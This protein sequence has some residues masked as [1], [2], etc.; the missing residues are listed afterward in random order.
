M[1][2]KAALVGDMRPLS[3]LLKPNDVLAGALLLSP[4]GFITGLFVFDTDARGRCDCFAG[5]S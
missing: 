1:L 5:S 3:L 2:G 4:S